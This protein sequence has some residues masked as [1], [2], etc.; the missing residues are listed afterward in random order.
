MRAENS[1]RHLENFW[2]NFVLPL[3]FLD[4]YFS[5]FYLLAQPWLLQFKISFSQGKYLV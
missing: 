3:A 1:Y 4:L 5:K 2:R